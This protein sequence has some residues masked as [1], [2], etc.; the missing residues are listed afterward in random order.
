MILLD[1]FPIKNAWGQMQLQLLSAWTAIW[2]E[3][4][5]SH[6]S[7]TG[8]RCGVFFQMAPD[9]VVRWTFT[10]NPIFEFVHSVIALQ[11]SG[12]LESNGRYVFIIL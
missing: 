2:Q 8:G 4:S 11:T 9:A 12:Y 5:H 3:F 6:N 1:D 10:H 7:I